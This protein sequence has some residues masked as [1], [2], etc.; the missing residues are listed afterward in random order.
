MEVG[1]EGIDVG[2]IKF[3]FRHVDIYLNNRRRKL[4]RA[5]GSEASLGMQ[6]IYT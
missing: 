4:K 5:K 2:G 6:E 3:R 1:A